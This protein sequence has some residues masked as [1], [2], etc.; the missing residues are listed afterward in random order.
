MKYAQARMTIRVRTTGVLARGTDPLQWHPHL[1]I[2]QPVEVAN[3]EATA[4]ALRVPAYSC[5]QLVDRGPFSSGAC[6]SVSE[7]RR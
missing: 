4:S 3:L 5:Q 2:L 1:P 6:C 7:P